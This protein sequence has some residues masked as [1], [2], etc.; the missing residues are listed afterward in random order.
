M[1]AALV[2]LL[3]PD[4]TE[5]K[6][7]YVADVKLLPAERRKVMTGRLLQAAMAWGWE[8]SHF[9]FSVTLDVVPMKPV[10][11]SGRAGIPPLSPVGRVVVVR[12]PVMYGDGLRLGD[13]AY[14]TQSAEGERAFLRMMRG[15]YALPGG[16]PWVRSTA[17]P[18]W[19]VHPGG[20]AC[21]RFEDRRKVRQLIADDGTEMRPAY[22]SCFGC[23]ERAAGV[24]LIAAALRRAAELGYRALRLCVGPGD[25]PLVREAAA[26]RDIQATG[27]NIYAT[28]QAAPGAEWTLNASEV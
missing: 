15:R 9:I 1:D 17:P 16:M 11:Y 6:S 18:V 19:L 14:L 26:G 27:G 23:T 20:G 5:R 24:E 10:E 8:E 28:E 7:A 12:A 4:G 25:L 3:L 21:G 2:R 13:E 22:L